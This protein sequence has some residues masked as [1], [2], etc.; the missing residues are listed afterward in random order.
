MKKKKMGGNYFW[1]VFFVLAA[2]FLILCP[3]GLLP[4]AGVVRSLL[5]IAC[6]AM[7]ISGIFHLSFAAIL[8]SLAFLGILFDDTLG[9]TEL[10]PWTVLLAALLGTI[11]LNLIF[12][13]AITRFRHRRRDAVKIQNVKEGFEADSQRMEGENIQISVSFGGTT[14]YIE[15]TDFRYASVNVSFGGAKIYLDNAT[16]PTGNAVLNMELNFAGTELYVPANWQVINHVTSLL[17]GV[18]E[19]GK[20]AQPVTATLTLEGN[21][22]FGGVTVYYV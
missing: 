3:L 10:N 15:S 8:F 16:V 19:K 11:G 6:V 17:G 14:R 5:A 21:T 13:K 9:M 4:E 2:A 20:A 12:G 22:R 7:L 18:A 1:G